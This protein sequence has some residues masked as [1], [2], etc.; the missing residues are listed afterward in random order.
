MDKLGSTWLSNRDESRDRKGSVTRIGVILGG[1]RANADGS[2]NPAGAYLKPPF[3]YNTCVDRDDDGLI[4]TLRGLGDR[5]PWTNAGG[6]APVDVHD[7]Y[8]TGLR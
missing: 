2:A 5:R 6:G 7:A 8:T 4:A 3:A 1:T